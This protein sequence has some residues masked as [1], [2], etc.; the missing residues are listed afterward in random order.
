MSFFFS[1]KIQQLVVNDSMKDK[2]ETLL[3]QI[4]SNR[5]GNDVEIEVK[6]RVQE[7][8][9]HIRNK[10]GKNAVLKGMN[11]YEKAT[12]RKRNGL[13]GGHNA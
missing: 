5:Y 13:V 7:A 8:L 10:Y 4:L 11:F 2:L 3:E 9:V 6:K 1:A 12:Q